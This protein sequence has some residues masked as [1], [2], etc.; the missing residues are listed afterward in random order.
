MNKKTFLIISI[1][2][3]YSAFINA[4]E[5]AMDLGGMNH[6]GVYNTKPLREYT[7]T[8]WRTELK[9]AG[10]ANLIIKD[11][12]IYVSSMIGTYSDASRSGFIY[13]IN[14]RDGKI[15]WQKSINQSISAPILKDTI[16]YYG[17]DERNGRMR[18]ISKNSGKQIWDFPLQI[19]SCWAPAVLD[20]KAFFGD[21]FGNWFVLN[22]LTGELLFQK[23]IK[24][25]IC[26]VPSVVD[27]MVYYLDLGGSL[28][29]FNANTFTDSVIYKLDEGANNSPV[30]VDG[31]AY[32]INKTGEIAAINIKSKELVWRFKTDD[33]MFRSPAVSKGVAT[34][35][36]TH[37]HIYGLDSNN[38]NVL[39]STFKEGLGYTNTIITNDIV[40]VG[41]ADNYLYAFNLM[42]GKELW[43][44]KSDSPVNTPLVN[45]GILYF[46]SGNYLY[47]IQ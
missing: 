2:I 38:G 40:Y 27:S 11:S 45:D 26:C 32:V 8:N 12:V 44:F 20:D 28:H 3:L 1:L 31:I 33:T 13:T 35:I 22:N 15:I 42:T 37:G 36:T 25:G 19:A 43:K 18:A 4:Q 7:K 41:C 47:S 34:V 9:G 17:S 21:H 6:Q 29:T 16:L 23:N 39:W 30:I 24:A 5:I 10:Q 14:C 46:T